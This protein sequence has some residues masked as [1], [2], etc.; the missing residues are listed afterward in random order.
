MQLSNAIPGDT[1]KKNAATHCSSAKHCS[2]LYAIMQEAEE[3]LFKGAS[4]PLKKGKNRKAIVENIRR[5]EAAGKPHTQAVAIA[6]RASG[7]P[8]KKT[9]KYA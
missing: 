9:G 5:E 4:M 2:R 7:R 1:P 8:P 3:H 6:L